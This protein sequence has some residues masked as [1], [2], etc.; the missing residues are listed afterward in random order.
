MKRIPRVFVSLA[1]ACT[2]VC[3]SGAA[4]PS[5]PSTVSPA[6]VASNPLLAPVSPPPPQPQRQR[7]VSTTTARH[8]ADAAPKFAPPTEGQAQETSSAR[9]EATEDR[10]QNAIV[11]LP[12]YV[13]QGERVPD[14]K[15]RE[16]LT[17]EGKVELAEKRHPGLRLG[18]VS[19]LNDKVAMAMLDED[20]ALERKQEM[21]ELYALAATG[22]PV[23]D[24]RLREYLDEMFLRTNSWTDTGGS[25]QQQRR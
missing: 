9:R 24:K 1:A 15:R 10:P 20:D 14:F 19:L 21:V 12:S 8:L 18:S 16:M 2:A 22:N 11:R 17:P 4:E 7:T 5:V 25:F 6:E 13:V 23:A 3:A